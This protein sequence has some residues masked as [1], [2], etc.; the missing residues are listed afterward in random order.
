MKR[1]LFL[2]SL[3]A[4][5]L[6]A[7][8]GGDE[9]TIDST[10]DKT[11]EQTADDTTKDTADEETAPAEEEVSEVVVDDANV[12]ITY[13]GT[14]VKE[15]DIFGKTA[16]IKFQIVNKLGESIEVQASEISA[17][18]VMV[19]DTLVAFSETVAAGKTANANLDITEMEGYD[20]PTFN[21]N[22]ELTLNVINGESW[23][24]IADYPV[25]ISVK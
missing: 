16:T 17:D 10:V 18:N 1:L 20:F 5:I 3:F 22:I 14:V 11:E 2:F 8:C 12:T 25:S 15:D 23:E 13:K 21:E 19:D 24:T 6:L 9:T 4:A 7:A